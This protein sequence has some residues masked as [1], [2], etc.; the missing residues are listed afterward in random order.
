MAG[1]IPVPT[2]P[3]AIEGLGGLAEQARFVE[4][5]GVKSA[6]PHVERRVGRRRKADSMSDAR[7]GGGDVDRA[8]AHLQHE[9]ESAGADLANQADRAG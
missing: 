5:Y 1:A 6:G 3:Q 8:E 4:R 7:L 9:P 2:R